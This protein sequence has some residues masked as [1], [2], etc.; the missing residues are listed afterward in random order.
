MR[1]GRV[2][3]GS[4][5]ELS[6][7]YNPELQLWRTCQLSL[8]EGLEQYLDRL[9]RLG[10]MRNGSLYQLH[11]LELPTRETG[12]FVSRI[13]ADSLVSGGLLPTPTA[14]G[15]EH[16]T[17]YS[18]GGRPLLYMIEKGML[19]TPTANEAKNNPSGASQWKR[20]DSLNVEAAK[21]QGLNKTTGKTFQLNPQFV[22]EMMG[23]PM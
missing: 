23:F 9:P 12:G 3:G 15:S 21:M 8:F 22:E 17:R 20:H 13:P 16:R 1:R 10:M 14:T 18:Q 4:T 6:T 19:P 11:N 5:T 7:S 2:F